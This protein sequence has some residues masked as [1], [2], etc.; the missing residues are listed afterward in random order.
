MA[1]TSTK[2]FGT[3]SAPGSSQSITEQFA[4][5]VADW[6]YDQLAGAVVQRTKEVLLDGIGTAMTAA[7]PR[8]GIGDILQAFARDTGGPPDAQ[9]LGTSMRTN[10]E[11]AALIN[12]TLGYFLDNESHHVEA[13]LHA[14]AIVG[15]ATLA[16]AERA[17]SSGRDVIL[18]LVTGID[19]ACRMSSALNPAALYAR[20]FDPS[21]VA[22][23]FGAMA[24]ASSVLGLAGDQLLSAYGLAGEQASGL[25]A[26]VSDTAEHAR[27]VTKGI[28]ARNGVTA[29]H[30]ASC[31]LSGPPA[32]FEGKY[33]LGTAFTGEFDP[34]RLFDGLGENFKVM[35]LYFK[36][37]ACVSFTHPG[38]EGLLDICRAEQL[39]ADDITRI[40]LRFPASGYKVI[41]GNP[42]RSHCAQY[43]LALAAYKGRIVFD[44]VLNDRRSEPGLAALSRRVSVIGDPV[45]DET[46]PAVYRTIIE[47]EAGDKTYARDITHPKGSAA[48]PFTTAEVEEKFR[49]I[50]AD[51]I[52]EAQQ[53]AIIQAICKL[54]E[55]DDIGSVC[56]LMSVPPYPV[57]RRPL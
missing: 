52:R 55:A 24:A 29:A 2:E 20:G 26:W 21:S 35:E 49:R 8:Y 39:Q 56:Q 43:L 3:M 6:K 4:G 1:V 7:S 54:E 41:D 32:I 5:R 28:A 33:P 34:A 16:V 45:L 53:D 57:G 15:P 37:Y 14:I 19:V 44:D 10:I 13:V 40:T 42:L 47:V 11:T 38:I 12:G 31:G 17:R 25:L 22:G 50:T 30:L 51:S 9:I 23:T 46:Y 36:D 48:N 27:P 18:A